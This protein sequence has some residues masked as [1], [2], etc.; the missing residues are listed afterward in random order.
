M[1][2]IIFVRHGK[3][4]EKG[5]H[6]RDRSRKLVE[7]WEQRTLEY[8]HAI[9]DKITRIDAIVSSAAWRT[10]MTAE[11]VALELGIAL[12]Q[13]QYHS[14][15][16]TDNHETILAMIHSFPASWK[17]VMVVWH[18]DTLSDAAMSLTDAPLDYMKKSGFIGLSFSVED[19]ALV[20]KKY[21]TEVWQYNG[22]EDM[23]L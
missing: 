13:I 16:W 17:H 3:A 1:K 4:E 2:Q 19:R 22:D 8:F 6:I 18:N 21:N 20:N 15:L 14:W 11:I 10:K 5:P 12:E 9:Q 7:K 23:S